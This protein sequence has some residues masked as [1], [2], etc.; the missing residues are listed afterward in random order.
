MTVTA[1]APSP[2]PR[3]RVS[4]QRFS[5]LCLIT[6]I[7]LGLIVISG[8][9][10]RLTGSGLGCPDW[11]SCYHHQLQASASIHPI[12]EFGNRL[13]T[14]ALCIL[15]GITIAAAHLRSPK[16]R[17]LIVFSWLLAAGV[18]GDA[19]LGGIVVYTKL[20]PYL[21]SVH[22]WLSLGMLVV[23]VVL[24]HRSKY[25]YGSAARAEVASQATRNVAR[26]IS[27]VFILVIIAGTGATGSGPHAGGSQGQLVAKRLPFA[28]HDV[29]MAH[30]AIATAFI[31]LV[32]ATF[33]MLEGMGAPGRLRG[34]AK[35]LLIV[36]CLQGLIGF[37]QYATHLP[38][39]LVEIH[40]LG[41]VSLTIG[42]TSFQLGQVARDREPWADKQGSI[43]QAES[44]RT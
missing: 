35:R 26:L 36:S 19:V 14:I 16:R 37:I 22:M 38:A 34:G 1:P 40:V 32:A 2:R 28:L 27:G 30:A 42:V 29:A 21:V 15:I 41:V 20:N 23:G 6:F 31:G 4:P 12:I 10:V 11:P 3:R 9:A 25:Q 5:Q 39:W 7:A 24:F 17:D 33:L 43:A 8:A 13:V 44:A 18:V